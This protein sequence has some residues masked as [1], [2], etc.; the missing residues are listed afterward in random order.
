M[1]KNVLM[2]SFQELDLNVTSTIL[3]ST[4]RFIVLM[5]NVDDILIAS[6]SKAEL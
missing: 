2:S 3:M 6:D 5:S 1:E 4:S